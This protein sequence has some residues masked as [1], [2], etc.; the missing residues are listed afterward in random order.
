MPSRGD[1]GRD[2]WSEGWGG[3]GNEG[4]VGR[5]GGRRAVAGRQREGGAG[6][7]GRASA[8][9][10]ELDVIF[11]FATATTCVLYVCII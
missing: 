2:G 4:G 1:H 10:S 8:V 7:G 6:E 3:C 11:C 9:L 5:S